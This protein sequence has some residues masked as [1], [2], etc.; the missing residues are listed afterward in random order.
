MNKHKKTYFVIGNKSKSLV[1]L[2]YLISAVM[3]FSTEHKK[4]S[5][6]LLI[7]QAGLLLYHHLISIKYDIKSQELSLKLTNL[8]YNFGV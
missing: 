7:I 6:L 1:E 5:T 2:I 8:T 3:V 4:P